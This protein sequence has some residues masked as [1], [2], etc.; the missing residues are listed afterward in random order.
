MSARLPVAVPMRP[1]R[2]LAGSRL[3]R[4][5]RPGLQEKHFENCARFPIGRAATAYDLEHVD[6]PI[7]AVLCLH[8]GI[9]PASFAIEVCWAPRMSR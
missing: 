6:V 5:G 2:S 4:E 1:G 8:D 9:S 7:P 3:R